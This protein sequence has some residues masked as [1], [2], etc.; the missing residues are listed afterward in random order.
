MCPQEQHMCQLN[1]TCVYNNNAFVYNNN[2]CVYNNNACVYNNNAF[3]YNNNACVYNNNT[4]IY[5]NN[6]FVYNN[7]TCVYNNNA[8]FRL[9]STASTYSYL[10]KCTIVKS[11]CQEC[12]QFT[13]IQYCN[14]IRV[15][16]KDKD[17]SRRFWS[18]PFMGSI[19]RTS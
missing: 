7:N 5:N 15:Y 10:H 9:G 1:N 6:A 11:V 17:K 19:V 4:C 18:T 3:V 14:Y 12:K 8:Y 16:H 13:A 2:T